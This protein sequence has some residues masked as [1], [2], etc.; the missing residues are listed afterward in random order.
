[1]VGNVVLDGTC[2][3]NLV[4][5]MKQGSRCDICQD[6]CSLIRSDT[7][8]QGPSALCVR[9][10][11]CCCGLEAAQLFAGCLDAVISVDQ[12]LWHVFSFLQQNHTLMCA[13][14]HTQTHTLMQ[15]SAIT[16]LL[17]TEVHTATG[18]SKADRQVQTTKT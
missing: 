16:V 10:C 6:P 17:T 4:L 18:E 8:V 5:D 2:S 1:M 12:L 13:Q 7:G 11:C 14:T 15:T 9:Q 3:Q